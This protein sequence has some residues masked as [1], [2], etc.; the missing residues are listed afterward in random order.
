MQSFVK[1]NAGRVTWIFMD[2]HVTDDE[3]VYLRENDEPSR[4]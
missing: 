3:L 4:A 1:D 2:K